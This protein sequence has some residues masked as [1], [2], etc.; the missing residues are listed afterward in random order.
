MPGLCRFM[1][2]RLQ[3]T[4]N[5]RGVVI[6]SQGFI[7]VQ[8]EGLLDILIT[9]DSDFEMVGSCLNVLQMIDFELLKFLDLVVV[10]VKDAS[11]R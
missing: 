5:R 1:W 8:Q 4:L 11:P 3:I 10:Q 2:R 6:Q 9:L 7:W